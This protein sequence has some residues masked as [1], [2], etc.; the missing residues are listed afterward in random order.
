MAFADL[1]RH[2]TTLSTALSSNSLMCL[3]DHR[4]D[5]TSFQT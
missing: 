2:L 3:P 5:K 1:V 4:Y